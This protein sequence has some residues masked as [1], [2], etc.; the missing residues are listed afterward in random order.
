MD[1]Q[2]LLEKKR[3]RLLE[4]QQRRADLR[5][6]D[7]AVDTAVETAVP[8]PK[9]KVD[10]G[11]EVDL[12][13][14][15]VRKVAA[16]TVARPQREAIRFDKGVQT[17]FEEPEKVEVEEPEVIHEPPTQESDA[18]QTRSE[19]VEETLKSKLEEV[20]P[21]FSNLRLGIKNEVA[22]E[23][24]T[25]KAPFN[26]VPGIADYIQRPV[27]ALA[28]TAKFPE[29]LLVAYGK[30]KA[31]RQKKLLT[32]LSGLAV[33][34]N[35]KTP[36][37]LPEFILQCS[38]TI[39]VIIFDEADPFKIIAGLENG[40]LAM[41]DLTGVEPNQI[42]VL[43]TLQSSTI[44]SASGDTLH[45]YTHHTSPIVHLHQIDVDYNS[46]I[47]SVCEDAVINVWSTNLLAFP[48]LTSVQITEDPQRPKHLLCVSSVV[49]VDSA[50]WAFQAQS[51]QNSPEYRFL[52][53]MYLGSMG[54][55]IIGV[56][57]EKE[58]NYVRSLMNE[59]C[60][61]SISSV[62]ALAEIKYK[63]TESLLLSAHKDWT[64]R[65]WDLNEDKL[66]LS[67]PTDTSVT[68][69]HVRPGTWSQFV[70][71]GSVRPPEARICIQFWDFEAKLMGPVTSIPVN[72]DVME[73][74]A[75]FTRDGSE[76]I[77]AVGETVLVWKVDEKML[78]SQISGSTR[79]VVDEGLALYLSEL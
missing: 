69:I 45:N 8:E 21:L 24:D 54:G 13:S 68:E 9:V 38:S 64:L 41:W 42:S 77:V 31:K 55:G 40:R 29:L 14:A 57:N 66:V 48:K 37:G 63:P 67:I 27:V 16:S 74:V 60:L 33:I 47:V 76:L 3:Q 18:A 25:T 12:V 26:E 49:L 79:A 20:S 34:F 61:S 72:N 5:S 56:G 30:S 70:T 35:R 78:K 53:H 59:T 44:A 36:G 46:S 75:T 32:S 1:R 22:A 58:K 4:L 73:A 2:A 28:T 7:V 10:F 50:H 52:S 15:G 17:D 43:P 62:T 71:I 39:K 19:I 51:S 65:L 6:T 11:V 23:V